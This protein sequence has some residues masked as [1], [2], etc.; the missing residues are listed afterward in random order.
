MHLAVRHPRAGIRPAAV[1]YHHGLN[2]GFERAEIAGSMGFDQFFARGARLALILAEQGAAIADEVLR[3]RDCSG[4]PG[5]IA[6]HRG[7]ECR[8]IVAHQRRIR[9]VTFVGSA[10]ARALHH[11]QSGG[12]NPAYAGCPYLFGGEMRDAPDKFGIMR[13]AQADIMRKQRCAE[14]IVVAVNSVGS[15]D[16]RNLGRQIGRHRGFMVV[17]GERHPIGNRSLLLTP[18]P[19]PAAV[20][21]RANIML[22]GLIRRDRP[23]IRLGHLP[24]FLPQGHLTQNGDD[25]GFD[26]GIVLIGFGKGWPLRDRWRCN[27]WGCTGIGGAPAKTGK[28]RCPC[29][30]ANKPAVSEHVRPS[31]PIAI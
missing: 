16:N 21:N 1:G 31:I 30:S 5:Q 2:P 9:R 27:G 29:K 23:D 13:R 26:R 14:H 22:A 28:R 8:G 18:R 4:W 6:L 15:P 10:P 17:A 20:Q 11:R 19:C 25:A 7:N 24:D 3:R 12:E